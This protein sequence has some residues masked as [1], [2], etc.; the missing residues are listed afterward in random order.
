MADVFISYSSADR[1][2]ARVLAE[3][4]GERGLTVWWDRTIPPGRVFDEVIQEALQA[5]GCVVVLWSDDSVKSNWVRTEAAEG[6]DRDKLVPALIEAV[7][8]PIEFKRIQAADLSGWAGD[9]DHPEYRKLVASVDERLRRPST[10]A[11]GSRP[12]S[13]QQPVA[14][15][16]RTRRALLLTA[17]VL[18]AALTT[19]AGVRWVA[20]RGGEAASASAGSGPVAAAAGQAR[21][22]A[23]GTREP[24]APS[25]RQPDAVPRSPARTASPG[26]VNLL[27]P[28][29]GG[30]LVTAAHER[31]SALIDGD[32]KTYAYVD[33]GEG[34]FAF[35]D[36]RRATFDTFAVLVP[37][38]SDTNLRDFELL[39]AD[40]LAGPFRSI[41]SFATQNLRI[42]K[43]PYQEFNFAPTQA[44]YLKLR[45]LKNHV[46]SNGAVAAYE[47]QLF[48]T[49][50]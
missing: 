24:A 16:P 1:E 48:G 10:A 40:D 7:M 2:S 42:M 34:V 3:R 13:P 4:L 26:R 46:G 11:R 35:K 22:E 27:S 19:W 49:L 15:P 29:N 20:G 17:A 39:V 21:P 47:I 28:V 41:G 5:A 30:E 6:L 33:K 23:P 36:G 31:W 9:S 14:A 37:D 32:E 25:T 44:K 12:A 45:S 38:T 43:N 18:L 8:P 50:E